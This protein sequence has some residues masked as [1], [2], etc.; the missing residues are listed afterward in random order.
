LGRHGSKPLPLVGYRHP[1]GTRRRES[2]KP[3]FDSPLADWLRLQ[4]VSQYAVAR[5]LGCDRKTV[6]Y[7]AQGRVLPTLIYAYKLEAF[8]KGG[9]P[10]AS[11]LGTELAKMMWRNMGVPKKKRA[12]GETQK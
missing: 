12:R 5:D 4:G 7:W 11:W 2:E 9:V 10:V 8:T 1:D 6:V 3:I